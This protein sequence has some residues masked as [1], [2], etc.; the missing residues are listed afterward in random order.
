M[1]NKFGIVHRPKLKKEKHKTTKRVKR[2]YYYYLV[3]GKDFMD[4]THKALL[5][6][7]KK[8]K[9]GCAIVSTHEMTL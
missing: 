3:V 9:L 5:I 1:K 7:E 8:V 4:R 2:E 6:K